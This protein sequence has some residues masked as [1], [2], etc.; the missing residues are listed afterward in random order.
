MRYT[1]LGLALAVGLAGCQSVLKSEPAAGTLATGEKV[2]VDDG[3]CPT[4][5]VKEVT[6]SVPGVPRQRE[7]VPAPS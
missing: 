1:I 3:S 2:L 7:C 5:L 6:G 4:G